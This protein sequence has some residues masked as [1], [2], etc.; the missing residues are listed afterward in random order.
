MDTDES[1]RQ[2]FDAATYQQID[3]KPDIERR[4]KHEFRAF[5]ILGIPL[6][7]IAS[8]AL[9]LVTNMGT[10]GFFI[11]WAIFAGLIGS[12]FSSMSRKR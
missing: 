2:R 5:W 8:F 6:G 9:T 1:D 12:A 4:E 7:L 10:A 11:A 3:P